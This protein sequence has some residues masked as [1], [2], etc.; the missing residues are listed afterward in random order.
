MTTIYK[1]ITKSNVEDTK[2]TD[3][4]RAAIDRLWNEANAKIGEQE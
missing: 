3:E 1:V 4:V 2:L